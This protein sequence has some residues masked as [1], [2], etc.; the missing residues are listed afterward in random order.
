MTDATKDRLSLRRT[1]GG[2]GLVW[3]EGQLFCLEILEIF[4]EGTVIF[5]FSASGRVSVHGGG[6]LGSE[7]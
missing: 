6:L 3:A 2:L 5:S 1:D 7:G 4:K